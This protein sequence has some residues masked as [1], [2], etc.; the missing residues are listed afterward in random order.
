MYKSVILFLSLLSMSISVFG[1][2]TESD[3]KTNTMLFAGY[4]AGSLFNEHLN[5]FNLGYNFYESAAPAKSVSLGLGMD[6]TCLFGENDN[7]AVMFG[8][9][10]NVV[11]IPSGSYSPQISFSPQVSL[12]SCEDVNS[13]RIYATGIAIKMD[14]E[15]IRFGN[16]RLNGQVKPFVGFDHN[17]ESG[18]AYHLMTA[19]FYVSYSF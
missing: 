14:I 17:S 2:N 19:S 18:T 1:Q 8:M 5:G 7:I 15:F 13:E 4:S 3:T 11:W 6:A 10:P 9:G 12:M 16:F